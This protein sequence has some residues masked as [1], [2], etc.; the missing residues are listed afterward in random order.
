MEL[1]N[2]SIPLGILIVSL[3]FVNIFIS[4]VLSKRVDRLEDRL[5]TYL[6][7]IVL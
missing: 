5:N 6:N 2:T 1:F 4:S 3:Q 7:S